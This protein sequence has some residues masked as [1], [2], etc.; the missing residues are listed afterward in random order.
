MSR[1]LDPD[2]DFELDRHLTSTFILI[3]TSWTWSQDWD[4]I[5]FTVPLGHDLAL[6]PT[7]DLDLDPDPDLDLDPDLNKTETQTW[8]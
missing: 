5:T 3:R 6:D 1:D 4:L 7:L 8:T 2:L